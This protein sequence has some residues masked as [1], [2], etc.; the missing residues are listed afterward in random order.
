MSVCQSRLISRATRGWTYITINV[1]GIDR[2]TTSLRGGFDPLLHDR[3]GILALNVGPAL[4]WPVTHGLTVVL[5]CGPVFGV[6]APVFVGT[7]AEVADDL[8][9]LSEL[10]EDGCVAGFGAVEKIDVDNGSWSFLQGIKRGVLAIEN[11]VEHCTRS[12]LGYRFSARLEW[13]C[14]N[15]A[16]GAGESEDG[17]VMHRRKM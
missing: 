8:L 4:A 16:G 14:G 6:L 11:N 3:L 15:Q 13:S 7:R 12:E 5:L 9:R 1:I 2:V 10:L 17:G